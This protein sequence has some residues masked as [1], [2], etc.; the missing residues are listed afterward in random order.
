MRGYFIEL[1]VSGR[2]RLSG[3]VRSTDGFAEVGGKLGVGGILGSLRFRFQ[4]PALGPF[5]MND[6]VHRER[7]RSDSGRWTAAVNRLEI[8]KMMITLLMVLDISK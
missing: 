6:K 2:L 1:G 8:E 4:N 7:P 3:G 5:I